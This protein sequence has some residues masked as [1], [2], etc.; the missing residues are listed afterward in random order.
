MLSAA[1]EVRI[2]LGQ[3]TF[4]PLQLFQKEG[5]EF[6]LKSRSLGLHGPSRLLSSA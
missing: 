2:M 1:C 5:F 3:H 6:A 4:L